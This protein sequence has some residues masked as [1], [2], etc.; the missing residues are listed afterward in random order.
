L[1]VDADALRGKWAARFLSSVLVTPVDI[2]RDALAEGTFWIMNTGLGNR[3]E[4]RLAA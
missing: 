2:V 4:D 3:A 1:K